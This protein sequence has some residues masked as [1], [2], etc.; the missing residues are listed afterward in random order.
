MVRLAK[1]A[2][3][4]ALIVLQAKEVE[5]VPLYVLSV[6][7]ASTAARSRIAVLRAVLGRLAALARPHVELHALRVNT[8]GSALL[9]ASIAHREATQ[10]LALPRVRTACQGLIVVKVLHLACSV[11]PGNTPEQPQ[12]LV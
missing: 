12:K 9:H 8:Q 5:R 2:L 11:R 3:S 4:R 7:L 10:K 1:I 6:R